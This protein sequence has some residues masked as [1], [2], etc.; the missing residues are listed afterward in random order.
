MDKSEDKQKANCCP[1]YDVVNILVQWTPSSF[2]SHVQ[3]NAFVVDD[4]SD[5]VSFALH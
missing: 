5:G 4:F 3:R 2:D 1:G